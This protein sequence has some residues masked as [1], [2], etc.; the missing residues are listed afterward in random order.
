MI[1]QQFSK[2]KGWIKQINKVHYKLPAS[3]G[4]GANLTANTTGN[5]QMQSGQDLINPFAAAF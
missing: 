5:S 1:N 3:M 2:L 4:G